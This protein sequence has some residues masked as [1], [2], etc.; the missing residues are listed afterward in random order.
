MT[1]G[2][3]QSRILNAS[4]F[5]NRFAPRLRQ[6]F[7]LPES[8]SIP[9]G[10]DAVLEQPYSS[11]HDDQNGPARKLFGGRSGHWANVEPR[12]AHVNF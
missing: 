5:A 7:W 2:K 3:T 11:D 10:F 6:K 9:N 12:N 4:G 1:S 8:A